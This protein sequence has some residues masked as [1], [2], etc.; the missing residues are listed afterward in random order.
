M[1]ARFNVVGYKPTELSSPATHNSIA[2][3]QV[4]RVV[5][6]LKT[7]GYTNIVVNQIDDVAQKP[8]LSNNFPRVFRV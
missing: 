1:N 3:N 5:K 4:K 7:L 6:N 2:S 8:T